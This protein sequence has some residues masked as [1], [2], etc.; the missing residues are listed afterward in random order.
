[1][2]PH[3]RVVANLPYCEFSIGAATA[4]GVLIREG[5]FTV[6]KVTY[7]EH[8]VGTD[9]VEIS[10]TGFDLQET[11][12]GKSYQM[13]C[14][15]P[16]LSRDALFVSPAEIQGAVAEH[17]ELRVAPW[18]A[19]TGQE[20]VN[21]ARNKLPYQT[22]NPLAADRNSQHR[23][24]TGSGGRLGYGSRPEVDHKPE[25]LLGGLISLIDI[26]PPVTVLYFHR[27]MLRPGFGIANSQFFSDT[28]RF[29]VTC[30]DTVSLIHLRHLDSGRQDF[31]K[32]IDRARGNSDSTAVAS[33]NSQGK[34]HN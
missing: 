31:Q 7:D 34:W 30:G 24:A 26:E 10:I 15:L 20:P 9:G 13:D 5:V 18:Q 23:R 19:Y 27:C 2:L 22:H 3:C 33:V 1:M 29:G 25:K 12:S 28:A 8:G 16:L 4:D 14:M 11:S 21:W 6:G 17:M 32:V